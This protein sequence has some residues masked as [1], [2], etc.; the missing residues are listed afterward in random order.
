MKPLMALSL[1]AL[2]CAF[3]SQAL[4][5]PEFDQVEKGRYLATVGDCAACHTADP[6]KPF[7]GGIA[8]KTPFGT[9]VGANITPD[10]ATGIGNWTYDDFRRAMSEGIGHDGKRLYGAMPFTAY[11]KVTDE[12]NRAIWAY[13]QTLQPINNPVETN[14]LPFPFSVRTSLMVWNWMNF[15]KGV[16]QPDM[17]KSAEWNRGAY[18]VQGL[19]HCGTCHTP[20][21]ILGGDKNDLFLQGAEVENWWAPNITANSH[22]GVGRWTIQEIKDY[23]R[24]GVN[25]YDIASGPMAEE[26]KHSSHAWSDA[27]LQAVAVYLKSLGKTEG[28]GPEPLP[29]DNPQMVTGKAIYFDRCSACHTSSGKGEKNIFPQLASSPLINAREPVSLM[30]VVLA[31]SRGVDT[32]SRPTA[33]AMPSFAATM[34]DQQIAD[35]LTYIRNSWD[36]A[37]PAVSASDVQAMREKLQE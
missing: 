29:A 36:N 25:R 28:K 5:Q 6:A 13:L 20:K 35:V 18:L 4:A 1:L 7:A 23:L 16:Y 19:G 27:D 37:A 10:T 30:R 26:V 24:T 32:D 22:E 3:A 34:T 12:D 31:G 15:D 14:Q 21:N 11:T 33:P 8:I 2:S 17:T 9:L